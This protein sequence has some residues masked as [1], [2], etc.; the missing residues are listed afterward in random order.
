MRL[1]TFSGIRNSAVTK[2]VYWF[3][4]YSPSTLHKSF[5]V[6]SVNKTPPYLDFENVLQV[7]V[8][9]ITESEPDAR[10]FTVKSTDF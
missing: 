9:K 7:D 3:R 6:L 1:Q 4:S 10:Y 8:R 5:T 2:D